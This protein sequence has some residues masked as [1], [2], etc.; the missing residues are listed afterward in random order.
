MAAL[1]WVFLGVLVVSLLLGVWRG[2]V[3]EVLS[4]A[5]W[6]VAFVVAQWFGPDVAAW[7]PMSG[8]AE[9]MRFAAGFAVT[10][11]LAVFAGGLVAA[12]VKRLMSAV[13]LAP[14]DRALGAAFGLVRGLVILLAAAVVVAMTPL[15]G[16]GWWQESVGAG[17][18]SAALRGLK[19][20][21]PHEFGKY[22]P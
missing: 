7:L 3:Y 22:L 14:V 10:F 15:K 2:L 6:A 19:P 13:G 11:V 9:S 4:L 21:L 16:S 18:S 1:D 17:I 5:A 8:A 12:L 20:V